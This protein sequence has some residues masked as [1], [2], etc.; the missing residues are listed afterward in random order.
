[1]L[2]ISAPEVPLLG[3]G[4]VPDHVTHLHLDAE[5][6]GSSDRYPIL[7]RRGGDYYPLCASHN[8]SNLNLPII[9]S[10][11]ERD[12]PLWLTMVA[13]TETLGTAPSK[14]VV[15]AEPL[16]IG[17]DPNAGWALPDP[18]RILST[19]HCRI[20]PDEEGFRLSDLSTNGTFLN[21]SAS[22]MAAEHLLRNGDR[23][24]LGPYVIAVELVD[25]DRGTPRPVAANKTAPAGAAAADLRGGDPAAIAA[26]AL[27]TQG[28]SM[29]VIRPAQKAP[30]KAPPAPTPVPVS[31]S[32]PPAPR[33]DDVWFLPVAPEPSRASPA[34]PA[35]AA[36]ATSSAPA[37]P[38]SPS[39][40]PLK[41]EPQLGMNLRDALA[42]R[43]GVDINELPDSSDAELITHLTDLVVAFAAGTRQLMAERNRLLRELGSRQLMAH[44]LEAG[45]PLALSAS[46]NDAVLALLLLPPARAGNT[47]ADLFAA[48]AREHAET[49]QAAREAAQSLASLLSPARLSKV[50]PRSG[51][52]ERWLAAYGRLWHDLAP[53]WG[54]GFAEAFR[55][56]FGAALDGRMGRQRPGS[57]G[58]PE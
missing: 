25:G 40:L 18:T 15:E 54:K 26:K 51:Q 20:T 2:R 36:P 29:T 14:I 10:V 4:T 8:R 47:V 16:T 11:W 30:A 17:R 44:R 33:S 24:A 1:M 13:S 23:I 32:T 38:S 55:L 19:Q 3:P 6:H 22:R 31:G 52:P 57:S 27:E 9:A 35:D 46:D 42:Q 34:A 21:G 58:G 28:A 45:E 56:E 5:L 39:A 37:T 50:L 49:G 12:V 43:L 7:Q 41:P 48:L 53:E